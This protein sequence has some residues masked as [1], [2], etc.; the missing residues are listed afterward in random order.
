M[1]ML[2]VLQEVAAQWV[3]LRPPVAERTGA[4]SV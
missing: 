4:V 2:D 3:G 1:A